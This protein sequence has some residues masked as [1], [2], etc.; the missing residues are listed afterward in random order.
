MVEMF[1]EDNLPEQCS[2]NSSVTGISKSWWWLNL[3][4]MESRPEEHVIGNSGL[5]TGGT[6]MLSRWF[7]NEYWQNTKLERESGRPDACLI[8]TCKKKKKK[9]N[10][11]ITLIC[12]ATL[13]MGSLDSSRY[14]DSLRAGR[15]GDQIPVGA[16]FSAPLQTSSETHPASCTMGTG[17]F[18]GVKQLGH[19]VDHPRLS[20]AKVKGKVELYFYSPTG[21]SWPVQGWTLPLPLP[22]RCP[23]HE[24]GVWESMLWINTLHI[25]VKLLCSTHPLCSSLYSHSDFQLFC[26]QTRRQGSGKFQTLSSPLCLATSFWQS[27]RVIYNEHKMRFCGMDQHRLWTDKQVIKGNHYMYT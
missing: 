8:V 15:F 27:L 11:S 23:Q 19:G 7:Q 25:S 17:S 10:H 2:K 1:N 9:K 3:N 13:S 16:R 12:L 24:I 26:S 6:T 4:V 20:S 18:L 5:T 22:L 21:P 14:S